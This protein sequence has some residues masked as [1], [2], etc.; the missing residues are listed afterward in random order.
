[1]VDTIAKLQL[2]GEANLDARSLVDN[3]YKIGSGTI[4]MTCTI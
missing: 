2:K 4:A 1:M 3:D